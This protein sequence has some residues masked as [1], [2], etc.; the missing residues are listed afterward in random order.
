MQ[1]SVKEI[2]LIIKDY[3]KD[4]SDYRRI[5][6]E[7]YED[8]HGVSYVSDELNGK[9]LLGFGGNYESSITFRYALNL[10]LEVEVYLSNN[11]ALRIGNNLLPI[12]NSVNSGLNVQISTTRYI[13]NESSL[14]FTLN[15]PISKI[16][17]YF[18]SLITLG[19][20][21]SVIAERLAKY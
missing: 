15:Y 6:F 16:D 1:K 17:D 5:N 21:V 8:K 9:F 4:E 18:I 14:T 13:P 3:L 20:M 7:K 10:G 11:K 19:T 12:L 2:S